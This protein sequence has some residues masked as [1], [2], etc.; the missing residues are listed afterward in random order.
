MEM[1]ILF[2]AVF[3]SVIG[4][5]FLLSRAYK[6]KRDKIDK[7]LNRKAN[8]DYDANNKLIKQTFKGMI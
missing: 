5:V 8:F 6:Y 7:D 4:G 3:A 2:L 1:I